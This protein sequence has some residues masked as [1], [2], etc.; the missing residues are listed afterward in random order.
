[1][2]FLKKGRKILKIWS[3]SFPHCVNE[4]SKVEDLVELRQT[5][6]IENRSDRA[7]VKTADPHELPT[8]HPP[9]LPTH[10]LH[11]IASRNFHFKMS[12][13]MNFPLISS[14][15]IL[16][17]SFLCVVEFLF[18][19]HLWF[20]WCWRLIPLDVVCDRNCWC[21]FIIWVLIKI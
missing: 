12:V 7:R 21:R 14:R 10:R 8:F 19:F 16:S 2:C 3:K 11:P 18:W 1:M 6:V 17:H 13:F 4:A 20:S 9:Q 5:K 15:L